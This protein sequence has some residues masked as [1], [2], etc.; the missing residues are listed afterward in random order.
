MLS[1]SFA[2]TLGLLLVAGCTNA[3][4]P[5]EGGE[6]RFDPSGGTADGGEEACGDPN[7]DAGNGEGWS[8]DLYRDYFRAER[9]ASCA[10]TLRGPATER[11]ERARGAG[12]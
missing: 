6:L 11:R 12:Q 4:A 2:L 10:G 5:E 3:P 1:S 7:L 8:Q 9:A